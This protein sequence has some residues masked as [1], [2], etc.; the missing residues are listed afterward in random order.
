MPKLPNLARLHLYPDFVRD[1]FVGRWLV[2]K[3]VKAGFNTLV[4]VCHGAHPTKRVIGPVRNYFVISGHGRFTVEGESFEVHPYELVTINPGETYSYE[5][6]MDLLELNVSPN[7]SF[8]DELI[9][10]TT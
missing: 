6:M 5:G 9:E 10:Q 7:N 2:T 3:E 4:I 8:E 1:G